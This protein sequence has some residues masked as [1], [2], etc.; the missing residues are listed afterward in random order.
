LKAARESQPDFSFGSVGCDAAMEEITAIRY[1]Y[2]SMQ[3]ASASLIH[4]QHLDPF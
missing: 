2:S 4:V 3:M 1:D